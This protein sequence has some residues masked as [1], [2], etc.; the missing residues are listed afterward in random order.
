MKIKNTFDHID[1]EAHPY[2]T[3]RDMAYLIKFG[4]LTWKEI[5]Q[6]YQ[7]DVQQYLDSLPET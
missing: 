4:A 1:Q 7:D 2:L 5:P 3:I 6:E